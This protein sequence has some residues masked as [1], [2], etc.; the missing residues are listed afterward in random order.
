MI[1]PLETGALVG[2]LSD[3]E[4][5]AYF[6]VYPMLSGVGGSSNWR[7]G[8]FISSS[9]ID[10]RWSVTFLV[11][12]LG[13]NAI[14]SSSLVDNTSCLVASLL[15]STLLLMTAFFFGLPP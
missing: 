15:L 10:W 13:G 12:A 2:L 11:Y 6:G 5:L 8:V 1:T 9:M 14:A 4:I 3:L 7:L